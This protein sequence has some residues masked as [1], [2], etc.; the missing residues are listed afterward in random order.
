MTDRSAEGCSHGQADA[1]YFSAQRRAFYVMIRLDPR[2]SAVAMIPVD[3]HPSVVAQVAII[4]T[5]N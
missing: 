4:H 1:L 5:A 2:S 3:P